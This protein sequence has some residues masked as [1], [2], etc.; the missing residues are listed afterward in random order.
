M[1]EFKEDIIKADKQLSDKQTNELLLH[2]TPF[3]A[4]PATPLACKPMSYKN[5][6]GEIARVLGAGYKGNIFYQGNAV[7][8]VESMGTES[9]STVIQSA[10]VWRGTEKDSENI[11]KIARSK[12]FANASAKVKQATLEK[13]FDV[14]TL[15]GSYTRDTLPTRYLRTY[16]KVEKTW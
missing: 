2:S 14:K 8:A 3:R 6:R 12:K 4:M 7:W 13:Y 11:T 15:F 9:L 16:A 5:Y 10:I 1:V